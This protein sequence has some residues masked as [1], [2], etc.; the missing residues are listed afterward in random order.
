[1]SQP[2]S[3]EP[4][5]PGPGSAD[6]AQPSPG[7]PPLPPSGYGPPAGYV[8]P[9]AP[10]G[11]PGAYGKPKRFSGG[12][13]VLGILGSWAILVLPTLVALGFSNVLS[14]VGVGGATVLVILLSGIAP[15]VVGAVLV[16]RGSPMRRGVG[17]G[18]FIGWGLAI[19]IG[20]GACFALIAALSSTGG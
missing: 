17:L 18:M 9:A 14:D 7:S 11:P 20:A 1:M 6:W 5:P 2:P 4:T 8:P 15:L 10:A 3:D 16:G 13:I 19:V 12:G